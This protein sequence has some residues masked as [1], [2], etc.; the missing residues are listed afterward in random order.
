MRDQEPPSTANAAR[1]ER[2]AKLLRALAE[3]RRTGRENPFRA[4]DV[5]A[6]LLGSYVVFI[7]N[8]ARGRLD[9]VEDPARDA[10]EITNDV[11]RRLTKALRNKQQFDKPFWRVVLD[12]LDWAVRDCWKARRRQVDTEAF[13]DTTVVP[14]APPSLLDDARAFAARLDGA[15]ERDHRILVERFYVGRSPTEIA[16]LLGISREACDTACSR[17]LARLRQG[18]S[19][20]DVRKRQ[21]SSAKRTR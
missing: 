2:D 8:I 4:R 11:L 19:T 7:E 3:A 17:A 16:E 1:D 12:N 5:E 21:D 18:E 20:A 9:G 13:D 15:S 10:E 14:E 6:Q